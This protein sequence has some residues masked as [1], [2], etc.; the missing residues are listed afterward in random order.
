MPTPS[1]PCR[2]A[3]SPPGDCDHRAQE[4]SL[5]A[6]PGLVWFA[7]QVITSLAQRGR[8]SHTGVPVLGIPLHSLLWTQRG[9]LC[10]APESP[11]GA[12]AG[13][14]ADR[15]GTRAGRAGPPRWCV[16]P[17]AGRCPHSGMKRP[18]PQVSRGQ[19]WARRGPRRFTHRRLWPRRSQPESPVP[20][21]LQGSQRPSPAFCFSV[22]ATF[23][24]Y[25]ARAESTRGP[26]AAAG[27]C[28]KQTRG[29]RFLNR[30][31]SPWGRPSPGPGTEATK[32]TTRRQYPPPTFGSRFRWWQLPRPTAEPSRRGPP[33][34]PPPCP[35]LL[36]AAPL[37]PP[38][39]LAPV[40]TGSPTR[41]DMS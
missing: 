20:R 6:V 38:L 29:E 34:R 2:P 10:L 32:E 41:V 7:S 3:L 33:P 4:V 12:G 15:P 5:E 39:H 13:V 25:K 23:S 19:A 35:S 22:A 1:V 17:G 18:G 27:V 31:T 28:S 11:R 30:S 40:I 37:Q 26:H 14:S 16:R 36:E 9:G 21:A 8:G 24:T